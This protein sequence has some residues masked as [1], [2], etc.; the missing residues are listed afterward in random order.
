MD[1]HLTPVEVCERLIAPVERLS[2]IA[3]LNE[4]AGYVWR[5]ASSWRD[6]GDMPSRVNRALLAHAAARGIPLR[7]DHL[8]WG[9]SE[10]EIN[11]LLQQMESATPGKVA[12]E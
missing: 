10:A 2:K 9:A 1:K 11:A 4:K 7:P 6:A 5:R 8:I 12:A 3:G